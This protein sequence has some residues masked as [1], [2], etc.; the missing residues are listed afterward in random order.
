MF[1]TEHFVLEIIFDYGG[2][3]SVFQIA[4]EIGFSS[5]YA[6]MICESL[7]RR[8]SIDYWAGRGLCILKNKGA[9]IGKKA[10]SERKKLQKT[11]PRRFSSDFSK[12]S[13]GRLIMGY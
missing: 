1:N 11:M 9:E 10:A 3:A 8:D 6:R 13:R 4:R 5:D 2:E 7:G 12:D